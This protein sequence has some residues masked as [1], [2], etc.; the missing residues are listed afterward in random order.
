MDAVLKDTSLGDIPQGVG[1][2]EETAEPI[3]GI[4]EWGGVTSEAGGAQ[5]GV[6]WELR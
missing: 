3:F 4:W 1:A 2:K 5:D 6:S